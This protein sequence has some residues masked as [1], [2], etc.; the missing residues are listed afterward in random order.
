MGPIVG[1]IIRVYLFQ[2]YLLLMKLFANLSNIVNIG[3]IELHPKV[4]SIDGAD[5][6]MLTHKLTT[7]QTIN[8]LK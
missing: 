2:G 6:M 7:T 8:I 4:K 1:A 3:S 5:Q